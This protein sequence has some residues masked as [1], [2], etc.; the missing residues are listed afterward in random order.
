MILSREQ[1]DALND[2]LPKVR[3]AVSYSYEAGDYPDNMEA[4]VERYCG[5]DGGLLSALTDAL[6]LIETARAYHDAMDEVERLT[7]AA[8][9][10]DVLRLIAERDAAR[11]EVERLTNHLA[12][13]SANWSKVWAERNAARDGLSA[14]RD[15]ITALRSQVIGVERFVLLSDLRRALEGDSDD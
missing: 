5:G 15:R 13:V 4:K 14:L 6:D 3:A 11:A 2:L 12:F 10:E 1:I 7:L 8:T 9:H